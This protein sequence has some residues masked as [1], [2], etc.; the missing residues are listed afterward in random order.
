M[1]EKV[2]IMR[3]AIKVFYNGSTIVHGTVNNA[4]TRNDLIN[5]VSDNKGIVAFVFRPIYKSGEYGKR[6][7][8]T[9]NPL[10]VHHEGKIYDLFV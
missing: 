9:F 8:V 5:I 4:F 10:I 2:I 3:Y 1:R 6:V 7:V